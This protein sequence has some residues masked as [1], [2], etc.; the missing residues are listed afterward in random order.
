MKMAPPNDPVEPAVVKSM[1]VAAEAE[2]TPTASAK[3]VNA[4][5]LNMSHALLGRFGEHEKLCQQLCKR[6]AQ[7]LPWLSAA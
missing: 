1:M 2:E 6:Q 3:I 4:N 7:R 5:L